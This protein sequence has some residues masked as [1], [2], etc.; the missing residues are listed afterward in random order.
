MLFVRGKRIC[1][2]CRSPLPLPI[3]SSVEGTGSSLQPQLPPP[4]GNLTE[5]SE[6]NNVKGQE[7]THLKPYLEHRVEA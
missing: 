5:M 3:A 2:T 7:A 6:A 1:T 4:P